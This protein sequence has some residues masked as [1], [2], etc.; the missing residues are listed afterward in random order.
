MMVGTSGSTAT[1]TEGVL[2]RRW[3]QAPIEYEVFVDITE[4]SPLI[5]NGLRCV[6]P[7]GGL[8]LP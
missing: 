8:N 4:E 7:N 3:F 2:T 5:R 6:S 1:D